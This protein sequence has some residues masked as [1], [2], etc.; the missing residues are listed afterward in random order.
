MKKLTNGDLLNQFCSAPEEG[1]VKINTVQALWGNI[2]RTTVWR[3][4]RSGKIPR[5]IKIGGRTCSWQISTLR[6]ALK[7]AGSE[8]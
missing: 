8:Q 5:P 2:S 1:L 4:I 7:N 6:E 3:F